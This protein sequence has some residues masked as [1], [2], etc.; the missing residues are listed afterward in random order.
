MR[1]P[2]R[3]PRPFDAVKYLGSAARGI[4]APYTEQQL[5]VMRAG[6]SALRL[7]LMQPRMRAVRITARK[8]WEMNRERFHPMPH[9]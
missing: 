7:A 6:S 2:R 1:R 9:K 8:Y 3:G 4:P 5:T